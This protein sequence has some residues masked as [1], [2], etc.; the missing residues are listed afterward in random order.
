MVAILTVGLAMYEEDRQPTVDPSPTA[1]TSQQATAQAPTSQQVGQKQDIPVATPSTLLSMQEV[2]RHNTTADC[3]MIIDGKVYNVTSY[4][5]RHPGGAGAIRPY[6]GKDGT[7]AFKGLPHS[8]K[9]EQLLAAY[10][11]GTL[12]QQATVRTTTPQ[13]APIGQQRTRNDE[14]E[15]DD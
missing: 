12:G 14:E 7:A 3:W 1:T 9:A 13:S 11:I 4:I 10:F 6:C 2:G 8:V 15:F 5:P